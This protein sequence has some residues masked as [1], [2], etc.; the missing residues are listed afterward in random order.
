MLISVGEVFGLN[1]GKDCKPGGP[2]T[3]LAENVNEIF[4]WYEQNSFARKNVNVDNTSDVFVN[5]SS[6]VTVGHYSS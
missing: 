2:Q 3:A 4:Y 6:F 5:F 1:F